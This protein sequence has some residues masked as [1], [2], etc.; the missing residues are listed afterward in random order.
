MK[1]IFAL[2]L[3]GLVEIGQSYGISSCNSLKK[4]PRAYGDPTGDF[5][6]HDFMNY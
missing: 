6:I 5:V 2:Q 3:I 4:S 1:T